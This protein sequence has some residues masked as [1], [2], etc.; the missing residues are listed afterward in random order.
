VKNVSKQ[1]LD[2]YTGIFKSLGLVAIGIALLLGLLRNPINK[3]MH[4]VA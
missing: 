1:S 2:K 4:G 3:L